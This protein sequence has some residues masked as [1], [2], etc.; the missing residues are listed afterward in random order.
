MFIV[1]AG[2]FP[3]GFV[4]HGPFETEGDAELFGETQ[5]EDEAFWVDTLSPP[6][7]MGPTMGE[8]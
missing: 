1:I 8:G 5:L 3:L 7:F 6:S 4:F 2:S